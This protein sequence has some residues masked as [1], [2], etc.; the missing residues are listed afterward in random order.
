MGALA[1]KA[2]QQSNFLILE[3]GG[4]AVRVKYLDFRFVPSQLDP[5]KEVAQYKFE[6]EFGIKFWT[7]GSGKVM[8]V[9]DKLQPGA[10]VEIIRKAAIG[11][12]GKE[13]SSKST[14]EVV[15]VK[16]GAS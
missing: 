11:K 9:F 6:T 2:K 5:S 8:N 10:V 16:D 14:Y 4:P 7:N 15:E 3:K 12:E 13:D 1:D